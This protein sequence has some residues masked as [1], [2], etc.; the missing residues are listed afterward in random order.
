MQYTYIACLVNIKAILACLFIGKWKQG[1]KMQ[2]SQY[3]LE[4]RKK[5]A[6][7]IPCVHMNTILISERVLNS[8]VSYLEELKTNGYLTIDEAIESLKTKNE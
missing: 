5:I 7:S 6:S 8:F 2:D 3:N 1:L 4:I